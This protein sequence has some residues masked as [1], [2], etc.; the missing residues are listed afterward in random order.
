MRKVQGQGPLQAATPHASGT[1][2]DWKP[3]PRSRGICTACSAWGVWRCGLLV[4]QTFHPTPGTS[5]TRCGRRSTSWPTCQWAQCSTWCCLSRGGFW[6]DR[7]APPSAIAEG[8]VQTPPWNRRHVATIPSNCFVWAVDQVEVVHCLV[9]R[10][11]QNAHTNHQWKNSRINDI[12]QLQ[13]RR[14]TSSP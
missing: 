4:E 12:V 7:V 5:C 1:R 8:L 11:N 2:I 6:L 3:F 9:Q 14:D 13:T 10:R